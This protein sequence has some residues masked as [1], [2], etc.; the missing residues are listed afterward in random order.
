MTWGAPLRLAWA[1]AQRADPDLAKELSKPRQGFRVDQDGVLVKR[2]EGGHA[3]ESW[4]PV[5]PAGYAAP[6]M[7][8]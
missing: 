1:A 3:P 8:C 5:V 4:V 6:H 7:T 2:V